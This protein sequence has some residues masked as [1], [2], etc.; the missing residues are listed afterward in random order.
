MGYRS[1]VGIMC[2]LNAAERLQKVFN[3]YDFQP[4]KVYNGKSWNGDDQK[5]FIFESVKWYENMGYKEVDAVMDV[6]SELDDIDDPDF[7]D[8]F[9][10]LRL[11]EDVTDVELLT[12]NYHVE[13]YFVRH[14][15][16]PS[17]MEELEGG[18]NHETY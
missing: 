8:S 6:L 17:G 1:D 15:D 2:G 9:K 12:N 18:E 16:I 10:Y 5:L 11:G 7:A 4:D 14:L 3:Q 13:L